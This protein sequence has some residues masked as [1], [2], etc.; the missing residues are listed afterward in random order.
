MQLK[1]TQVAAL[2]KVISKDKDNEVFTTAKVDEL[3]GKPVLVASNRRV[4]C[5][6]Y[7]DEEDAQPL[8]GNVIRRESIERW[9]KLATGKSRLTT[10]EL[11]DI[12]NDDYAQYGSYADVEYPEWQR[13]LPNGEASPQTVMTFDAEYAKILQDLDDSDSMSWDLHGV[14]SPLKSETTNGVYILAPIFKQGE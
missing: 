5:A 11:V 3:D 13:I 8:M 14:A 1:K 6:L 12:S 2:L 9:Y 10:L 7:L 4:L